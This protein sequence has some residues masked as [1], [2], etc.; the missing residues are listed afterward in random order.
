MIGLLGMVLGEQCV[1]IARHYLAPIASL[2]LSSGGIA[3]ILR[4][5]APVGAGRGVASGLLRLLAGQLRTHAFED[6]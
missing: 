2:P 1:G 5:L 4:I 3:L 6:L